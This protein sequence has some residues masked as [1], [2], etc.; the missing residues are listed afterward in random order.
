MKSIV[1]LGQ[2]PGL[3]D[4]EFQQHHLR[5]FAPRVAAEPEV[6]Q[7]FANLVKEP[8]EE[9]LAAG[10]GWGGADDTGV[11]AIDEIWSDQPVDIP[12]IYGGRN[13]IGSYVVDEVILRTAPFDWPVGEKSPWVKRIGLL[14]CFQDQRVEDFHAYWRKNHAEIALTHHIGAGMYKQNHIVDTI[15]EAPVDWNGIVMLSYWN[16]EA[17]RL[18]HFSRPDSLEVVKKDGAHFMEVFRAFYAEEYILKRMAEQPAPVATKGI[19]L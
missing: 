17:F 9:M 15:Q 7:Y 13:V 14:K 10:W 5:E 6:L 8:T 19:V 3:S 12:A 16:V 2:E 4:E 18:G 1:L 11:V